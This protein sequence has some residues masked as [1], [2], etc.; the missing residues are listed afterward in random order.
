MCS[1]GGQ[2]CGL[3]LVERAVNQ[4]QFR[5]QPR[6]VFR[7]REVGMGPTVVADLEAHLLDFGNL[8]P[9]HEISPVVHPLVRDEKCRAE[10]QLFEQWRDKSAMRLDRVVEGEHHQL[11]RHGLGRRAKGGPR[12]EHEHR[13]EQP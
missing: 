6:G 3:G 2:S 9:T 7:H 4:E 10:T 11:V 5:S 13:G 12:A 1:L 8:L